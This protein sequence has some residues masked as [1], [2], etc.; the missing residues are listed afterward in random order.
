MAYKE[1][2]VTPYHIICEYSDFYHNLIFE[3]YDFKR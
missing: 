1:V 3:Y 2:Y